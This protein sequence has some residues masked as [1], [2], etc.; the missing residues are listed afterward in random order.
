MYHGASFP[1]QGG[2]SGGFSIPVGTGALVAPLD[3]H[4]G[5]IEVAKRRGRSAKGEAE[6][7]IFSALDI[8][9]FGG[10]GGVRIGEGSGDFG[11]GEKSAFA[12]NGGVEF[13]REGVV[14]YANER[15]AV[16]GKGE[17]DRDVGEGVYEVG[18]AVDGVN[19]ECWGV[20]Q[21][22]GGGGRFFAE[23]TDG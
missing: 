11:A 23:K 5:F 15:F 13:L 1:G 20:G 3:C 8:M 22:G 10:R 7:G 4:E 16:V 12:P 17:R 18:R 2:E 19:D 6:G 14:D 21:A 9:R